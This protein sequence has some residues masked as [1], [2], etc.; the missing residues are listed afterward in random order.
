MLYL[1]DANVLIRANLDYYP[2]DRVPG[3]WAWICD[4]A[5]AGFIKMPSEVHGEVAVGTDDLAK[6]IDKSHVKDLLL[7]NEEVDQRIFQRVL[8]QGYGQDLTEDE[9][10]EMGRDAFLVAYALMGKAGQSL[11][12]KSPHHQEPEAAPSFQMPA[13]G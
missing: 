8:D 4:Q 3:F 12:R 10:D 1:L 2:M 11:P 13:I 5:E 7:L 6:W 9:I